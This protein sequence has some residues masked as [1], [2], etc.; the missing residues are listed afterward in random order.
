M[1][2]EVSITSLKDKF[3]NRNNQYTN[4]IDVSIKQKSHLEVAQWSWSAPK[5][6]RLETWLIQASIKYSCTH[7]V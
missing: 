7:F 4:I 3:C 5:E 1:G 2:V 6:K